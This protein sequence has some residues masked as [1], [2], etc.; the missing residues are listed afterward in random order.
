MRLGIGSLRMMTMLVSHREGISALG[1]LYNP[2]C[3][4]SPTAWDVCRPAE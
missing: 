4:P 2:G 3:C 1:A